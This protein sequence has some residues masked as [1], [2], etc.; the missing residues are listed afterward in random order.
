VAVRGL[1]A[2]AVPSARAGQQPDPSVRRDALSGL[3]SG[4]FLLAVIAVALL[5]VVAAPEYAEPARGSGHSAPV[6]AMDATSPAASDPPQALPSP[7][8]ALPDRLKGYRWPVQGGMVADYYDWDGDGRYLIDERRVNGGLVITWFDGALVKSAHAGTV[9]AAGRDWQKHVGYDG[10]VDAYYQRLKRRKQ[11]PSLGV[12]VDDGNGYR[13]VYSELKDL[14]VKPNQKVKAG[15]VIGAM[16]VAEKR[17]M[18]RY[19]LVRMD[20]DLLK[21]AAEVRRLGFP[22]YVREHVDPLAVLRLDA[23]RKPL[24]DKRRP[25]ADPPRLSRY[26]SAPGRQS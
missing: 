5:I 16:S 19:E 11:K 2:Y 21:V 13:S 22:G 12:V 18:M 23:R 3:L 10:D 9:V 24:T 26:G 8:S 20:G 14:R 7:T 25:P 17:Y 6:L 1:Q 4:G 15:T